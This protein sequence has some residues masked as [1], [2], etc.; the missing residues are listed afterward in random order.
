[1]ATP[2]MQER[3]TMAGSGVAMPDGSF[4]IRDVGELSDAISAVGRATPNAGESDTARRNAVRRHIMKRARALKRTDMIPDTWNSDGSLK[5]SQIEEF[6]AHFGVKGMHWGERQ[7]KKQLE[8][9]AATHEAI[10]KAHTLAAAHVQKEHEQLNTK[11]VHSAPFKRVYGENAS[12]MNDWQFYARYGGSKAEALGETSNN[13]R[14][15]HNQY[16]KSA[17]RHAAKAAA[18]R[19]HAANVQHDDLGE[20]LAHYGVLGMKWGVRRRHPSSSPGSTRPPSSVAGPHNHPSLTAPRP[21]VSPEAGRAAELHSLAR[22]HGSHNLSNDELKALV[23]RLN[24]EDQYGRLDRKKVSTGK[25]VAI[26]LLI[27]TGAVAGGI[28]KQTATSFGSKYATKGVEE[29]IKM[30]AKK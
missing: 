14:R 9:K 28:A 25:K 18:L 16:V 4:Y 30:A 1:M 3:R 7:S 24:L 5:H 2:T 17:N 23:A 22:S 26:G 19:A 8:E 10:V 15:L 21:H 20:F 27:A 12:Q 11:G 29:L 13:L 6:L